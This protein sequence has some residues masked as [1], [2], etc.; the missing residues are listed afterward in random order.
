MRAIYIFFLTSP[1]QLFGNPSVPE[2]AEK[3]AAWQEIFRGV[4]YRLDVA[5]EPRPMRVHQ[6]RIDTAAEGISFFTTPGNGDAPGEV[7]GRRTTTFL[8]EFELELAVNGTGF[9][10]ITREG[11]PVD[12]LGL[13]ISEGNLVSEAD[14]GSNNPV[15]LVTATNRAKILRAPLQKEDWAD[16]E[17]AIQGWAGANGMLVDDKVVITQDHALHPRTAVGVSKDGSQVFLVVVD[18]RQPGYSEGI[19]LVELA[20]WMKKLGCW[21]A[22]N[23]D[24]GGSST[25]V[26]KQADLAPKIGNS[27]SGGFE[28]SVANHL[29]IHADSL[30]DKEP[31]SSPEIP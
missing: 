25:L 2:A 1:G 18:G 5:A 13:A 17:H 3:E 31:I 8:K 12:V 9:Q 20:T 22:I 26:T 29:G 6:I 16:A 23:L 7:S 24:G 14:L 21:D 11:K 4:E 28:R 15:F 19:T 10:P 27:V 30:P